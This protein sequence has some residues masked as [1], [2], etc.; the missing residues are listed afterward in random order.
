MG[1]IF[2]IQRFSL[3]DGP[4]IR[5]VV[6]F[7]GC[8]QWC[9]WCHNPESIGRKPVVIRTDSSCSMCGRCAAACPSHAISLREG[10]YLVDHSLCTLC[11]TCALTCF[12][13]C[14]R[15]SGKE[16]SA[17]EVMDTV[18]KDGDYYEESGGGITVSGGEPTQQAEFLVELLQKCR[19]E[20][21]HTAI[22][23]NGNMS[24]ETRRRIE[25]LLDYVMLDIKH[26]DSEKSKKY[27]GSGA[28][29]AL[30]TLAYLAAKKPVEVRVPV[31]P[32]FNDTPA[33][34]QSIADAAAES[35]AHM[36]RFLPYHTYGMSKYHNL[37]L[38]Y[39]Y[40]ATEPMTTEELEKLIEFVDTKG[41]EVRLG[42]N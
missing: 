13:N 9:K 27:T 24:S 8:N 23:T 17:D 25:P 5:T 11:G 38:D 14:F 7:Q 1:C 33:E 6:F 20:G 10:R 42:M 15:I 3:D 4:G 16:Y 2:D 31:V 39:E 19:E 28:G 35:G 22:E 26:T 41:L 40:P 30:E 36:I 21:I 34:L 18:R 37:G 29:K 32:G 12:E